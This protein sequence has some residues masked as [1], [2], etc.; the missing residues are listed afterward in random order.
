VKRS[1][2]AF[3][4]SWI[5]G[6][7][8]AI[9]VLT[10]LVHWPAVHNGFVNWDDPLYLGRVSQL[11][12]VSFTSLA[13]IFTALPGYYQPFA[14]LSHLVDF[15]VWGWNPTGHHASSI[16]LHGVNAALVC[17]LIWLLT[18]TTENLSPSTRLVMAAGV[19]I[20][21][22]I[23]PLQV[24]SVAWLA[25]RKTVL[26]GLFSLMSLCAYCVA[27]ARDF[28]RGWWWTM[29]ILFLAALLSKPM[30]VSLT[31][32]MLALD[33]FPLCRL[34]RG[35][36]R[37]L[38]REKGIL[39]ACGVAVGIVTII[40]QSRA[41]A[42][43]GLVGFGVVAR[44]FV[45][46][47]NVLFYVWKLIW[48]AWLSPYYPLEGKIPLGDT[49][50]AG[51]VIV[52]VALTA[53]VFWRR[54]R[55]PVVWSAWCAYLALIAPVSGLMQVGAQGAGDRFMYL[56]MIPILTLAAAGCVWWWRHFTFLGRV[57]LAGF[58]VCLLSFYGLRA[59]GQIVTWHD[60]ESLWT[61]TVG[62]FPDSV[63]ANWKLS[64]ALMDQQRY[65]DA[66]TFA[67]KASSLD[68]TYA[69][70][71]ATLGEIY[72]K[73]QQYQ[74]SL[75][76]LREALRL[77]ANLLDARYALACTYSRLGSMNEAYRTL[78]E[79]LAVDPSYARA[80]TTDKE[81]TGLRDNPEFSDR[82]R[83]LLGGAGAKSF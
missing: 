52:V 69:P 43:T 3:Q 70:I 28:R 56:A 51:S 14:W 48:P 64:L 81:L 76:E 26:C 49:E 25:E 61:T 74:D 18:G 71:R 42:V 20:T 77:N 41:G 82:M 72:G 36:W 10:A 40:S 75:T 46:A 38:L 16:L 24:E 31:V 80:A 58:L 6:A 23:H 44:C 45:A 62:Y 1:N 55:M 32:V 59:R 19:A 68:P 5:V 22:G 50:F 15:Q 54:N 57:A 53:L 47:R 8:A 67:R 37:P 2:A 9:A 29:I 12:R 65:E 13:W 83:V 17:I 78:Q 11:K 21:F 4:R 73:T 79:L 60:D 66:V 35:G 34:A 39:F 27:V 30:A 33:F 7:A 63:L